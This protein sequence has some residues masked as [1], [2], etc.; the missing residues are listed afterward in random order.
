VNIVT[1]NNEV[2]RLQQRRYAFSAE[3][4]ANDWTFRSE[5]IHATGKAFK[6]R[7]QKSGD[8]SDC[9]INEAIGDKADG[10]YALAIAPVVKKKLYAKA[11]Y[12]MYRSTGDWNSAKTLYEVGLNYVIHKNIQINAEYAFVNDR[13]LEKHNYNMFDINL[14]FRF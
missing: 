7:N 2:R 12:D 6:T 11:R 1:H 8:T 10:I 14:D 3:Y 5:Y 4:K 9:T 13:S